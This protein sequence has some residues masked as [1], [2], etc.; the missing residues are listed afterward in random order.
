MGTIKDLV[1][2]VAQLNDSVT[3]RK[4]AGEL[5]EIQS[6][7]A[8]LQSEHADIHEKRIHL[9][10]ENALLRQQVA[11]LKEELNLINSAPEK[12]YE[13]DPTTLLASEEDKILVLLTTS[14][15]V[16]NGQITGALS[17]NTAK[18]QFWLSRL[19]D[20]KLIRGTI[21][22]NGPTKY[23]LTQLGREY[24]VIHGHM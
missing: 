14:E 2:L 16:T 15:G 6:M 3:D 9:M 17:C 22:L 19:A 5:R 24:L 4:F 8:A 18:A 12:T 10:E 11:S 23:Y 21:N 1:D 7:I 13:F 20:K